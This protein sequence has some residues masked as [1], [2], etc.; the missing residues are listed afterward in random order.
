VLEKDCSLRPVLR[1]LGISNGLAW[2]RDGGTMFHIDTHSACVHAYDYAPGV[3]ELRNKRVAV[4][5]DDPD[6]FG[7][8]DGCC[9]DA[10]DMLWIA[11]WGGGKVAR[12]DPRSGALL[13]TVPLPATQVSSCAFGGSDCTDLLVTTAQEGF[14]PE[15]R[16]SQPA[17][18]QVFLLSGVGKGTGP[19]YEF[20]G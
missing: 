4:Q 16:A 6:H 19:A 18:G 20:D 10:D 1:G 7:W 8:P 15:Q 5:I 2:S 12:Y 11:C 14:S 13:Q 17:A 9:T 3:T